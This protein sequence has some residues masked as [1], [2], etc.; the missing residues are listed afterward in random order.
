M[1]VFTGMKHWKPRISEAVER[2]LETGASTVVGLVLAPHYSP[3]SI[4]GYRRAGRGRAR[5]RR[6]ARVRRALGRRAGVRRPACRA[7][8]RRN[9]RARRLHRP[10][11]SPRESST[12]ATY[13]EQLLETARL[14]AERGR[15]DGLVVLV[16]V[17]VADRRAL[18]RPGHP[19]PPHDA[20]GA[21]RRATSLALPGRLRRRPPRDQMGPRRRGRG[22]GAGAGPR[23]SNGSRCRTP[24]PR[25]VGV[26]AGLVRRAACG[27]VESVIRPGEIRVDEVSR[28]FRV[29]PNEA[30][31]SRSS[32]CSRG[33]GRGERR[34]GR[35]R[36]SRSTSSRARRS[37]LVGRNGSGKTTLL[38][39]IA[40]IIKPSEGTRGGRRPRRHRCS[41]SAQA[42]TRS[43]PA[44]R[45]SS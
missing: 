28:R 13:E 3:L 33:R 32:S 24:I 9:R 21:R 18:A 19:R 1:P 31:T 25:F 39:L 38:Q 22:A 42:F 43:S 34:A 16:P 17:R 45:T 15:V 6:G 37:G 11:A 29:Y 30:R 40:G 7:R 2:A 8:V 41:S 4:A 44:V 27:T 26:L 14:V 5:R 36:T 10:L 12:T 35:S 23:S 20:R